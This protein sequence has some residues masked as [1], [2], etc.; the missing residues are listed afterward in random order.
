MAGGAATRD[1]VSSPRGA[2]GEALPRLN[3]ATLADQVYEHLRRGI[4]ENEYEAG[5]S[6]REEALAGRLKVSRVPVREALRRLAAEGLVTVIP[7]QGTVV[8]SL[9]PRQ[10]LDA[11]RVREALEALAI[12]LAVPRLTEQDLAELERL[13][14]AMARHAAVEDAGEFFAANAAFHALFVERA[15]NGYLRAIYHPLMDQM[16]RYLTPS[17]DLRGGMDRSIEEHGA[18]LRAVRAGDGEEAA[19][20]LGEHIHVPQR[21]LEAAE[22]DDVGLKTE[23]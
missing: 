10:F 14:E 9:S 11:Y 17:L 2:A 12:R 16:R 7:R 19:R 15:E 5:A 13:Q 1:G 20:L 6:L 18:I 4:L 22:A 8:S 21:V 23:D 3:F